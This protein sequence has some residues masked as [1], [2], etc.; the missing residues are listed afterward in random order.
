MRR[1]EARRGMPLLVSLL[2]LA[3]A[4]CSDSITGLGDE[5]NANEVASVVTDV[6]TVESRNVASAYIPI[7]SA[8]LRESILAGAAIVP[9]LGAEGEFQLLPRRAS[10]VEGVALSIGGSAAQSV[11]QA[12]GSRYSV[13]QAT[14]SAILPAT[15]RGKTFAL[16]RSLRDSRLVPLHLQLESTPGVWPLFFRSP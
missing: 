11:A 1:E 12:A 5:F 14:Q 2:V 7:V 10:G 6:G 16:L 8:A 3:S 15:H 4:S 13:A 9:R